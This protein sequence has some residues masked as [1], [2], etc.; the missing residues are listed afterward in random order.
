MELQDAMRSDRGQAYLAMTLSISCFE[1][2][3]KERA[4]R[5]AAFRSLRGKQFFFLQAYLHMHHKN[6]DESETFQIIG[7]ARGSHLQRK[8]KA[9]RFVLPA[10]AMQF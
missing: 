6:L 10:S 9:W 5:A 3:P 1:V 7:D 2:T 8:T 4:I